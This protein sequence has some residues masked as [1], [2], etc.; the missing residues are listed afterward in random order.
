M[1]V[2]NRQSFFESSTVGQPP[3][4]MT[5]AQVKAS[6]P[7]ALPVLSIS[8]T[9]RTKRFSHFSGV[10]ILP[11]A[12]TCSPRIWTLCFPPVAFAMA[13]WLLRR[14]PSRTY[15]FGTTNRRILGSFQFLQRNS[16]S[17]RICI[18]AQWLLYWR[19]R[20][21]QFKVACFGH[22]VYIYYIN[23]SKLVYMIFTLQTVEHIH[24]SLYCA[25]C[26]GM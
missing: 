6:V 21:K 18:T 25:Q 26:L 20:Y 11:A 5:V 9:T 19:E 23:R 15:G 22:V 1:T 13:N 8:A 7:S 4:R 3:R 24:G 16:A 17:L 12:S 2:M 10:A 14:R